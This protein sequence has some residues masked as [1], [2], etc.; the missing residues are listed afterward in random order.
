MDHS[1]AETVTV[2]RFKYG[3]GIFTTIDLK[4]VI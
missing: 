4:K 1:Y 3:K 2:K